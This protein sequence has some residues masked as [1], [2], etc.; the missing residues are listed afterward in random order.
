MERQAI[1][2]IAKEVH[3][4]VM[5]ADDPEEFVTRM[6]TSYDASVLKQI[7]GSYTTAQIAQ[8]IIQVEP[9][10]GGT[11]PGGQQ[12]ISE[13]FALLREALQ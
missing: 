4:S 8:G 12:F 7:V 11:T 13:A 10:S 3:R 5:E 9:G 2:L 6:M 1:K